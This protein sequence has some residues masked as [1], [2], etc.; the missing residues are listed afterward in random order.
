M[1]DVVEQPIRAVVFDLDGTLMDTAAEISL[2]LDRTFGAL[3]I[4]TLP[5][6][7][8]ERLIG[9]GIPSLV[10][11]ALEQVGAGE[12]DLNDAVERFEADYALTVATAAVLYPGVRDGLALLDRHRVPMSVATN[13]ARWFSER[14]LA[15]AGLG[16]L[17]GGLVAGDDGL[18]RKPAGDMLAA[19]C[20]RMGSRPAE[21]LMLG[22]SSNDVEAAR[23]AGCRIWCVPYGYNEGRAVTTLGCD[24]IVATVDEAAR[25]V[26]GA[27]GR[28][29]DRIR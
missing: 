6:A 14:L 23:A 19:A 13:K 8:V 2:A 1:R 7:A 16:R 17:L 29:I 18:R 10:A 24:R 11:R 5:K 21:T 20:A 12:I 4:P 3:G 26:V 9:R 27:S 28:D 25:L 15:R 22:D